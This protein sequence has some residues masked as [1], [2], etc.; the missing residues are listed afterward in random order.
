[1]FTGLRVRG[2]GC[3]GP[4]KMEKLLEFYAYTFVQV[5]VRVCVCLLHICICMNV[6][7]MHVFVCTC[8][9]MS[10]EPNE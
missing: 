9:G 2:L 4:A 8:M 10:C 6:Y 1:M 5:C 7:V 3:R